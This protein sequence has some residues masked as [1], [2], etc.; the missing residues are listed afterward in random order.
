MSESG[1]PR[2]S[3][4]V[5]SQRVFA[6]VAGWF[7]FVF[8]ALGV[9]LAVVDAYPSLPS[10]PPR[11]YFPRPRLITR[12]DWVLHPYIVGQEKELGAK[13]GPLKVPI[14]RAMQENAKRPDPYA[15]PGGGTP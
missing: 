10:P 7:V 8:V 15:P 13:S 9:L 14:E 5:R 3:G 11:T 6:V 2:E 4:R 12:S 1:I